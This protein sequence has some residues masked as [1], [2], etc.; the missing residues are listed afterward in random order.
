ML[1]QGEIK[2]GQT[3]QDSK[4]NNLVFYQPRGI[5]LVGK[6]KGEQMRKQCHPVFSPFS[7][8][9]YDLGKR[10]CHFSKNNCAICKLF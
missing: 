8:L 4:L 9:F 5:V 1:N 6:K 3:D 7:M 2:L 10:N